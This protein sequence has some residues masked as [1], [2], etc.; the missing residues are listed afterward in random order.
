MLYLMQISLYL[1]EILRDSIEYPPESAVL[2]YYSPSSVASRIVYGPDVYTAWGAGSK[3]GRLPDA[4]QSEVMM[5]RG[6]LRKLLKEG[7]SRSV[8]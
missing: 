5:N 1:R 3:E 8:L 2:S 7:R 4:V 6:R